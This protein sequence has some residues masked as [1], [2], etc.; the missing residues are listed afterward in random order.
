M[1]KRKIIISLLILIIFGMVFLFLSRVQQSHPNKSVGS[2][3][4]V[5]EKHWQRIFNKT[6]A[7]VDCPEPRDPGSLP[8][9]YYKGPVIDTHIHIQSLPDGEPGFPDEYYTGENLGIKYSIDEW[10]CMIDA[11]GTTK[12]FG[13]FP[14]WDPIRNESLEFVKKTLE[15]YPGRFIPFIMPPTND[16][17]NL[18]TISGTEL[19]EMLSVYPEMF[20]GYGEIG[21]YPHDGLSG[22]P[23]D[24]ELF[25]GIYPVIRKHKLLVYFHL[26]EGQKESLEKAATANPDII[27]IFHGDQLIDCAECDKTPNAVAEILANHPNVY[28]GVDELYG[29]VWLFRPRASKEDFLAHFSDYESLLEKDMK[30]WKEFIETHPDQVLFGTDR[31]V[32]TS[33]DKDPDVAV[34]LNNYTRAF[35]GRLAPFVQEKFAY[36][37]AE[38]LL[39]R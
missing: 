39:L 10:A 4:S 14:V 24:S 1:K 33:W 28:Y 23:P 37:N 21:L 6:F 3:I 29:N 15:Q 16:G 17:T 27:F 38:K 35:I 25:A 12:A 31:G 18:S 5:K 32:S 19:D 22:L 9:G 7:P 11:E 26:G 20:E 34:T 36:Q 13:F 30:N 2:E 8:D